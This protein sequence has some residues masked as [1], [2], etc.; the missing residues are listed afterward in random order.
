MKDRELRN[1]LIFLAIYL[2]CYCGILILVTQRYRA[3]QMAMTVQK[4]LL[5]KPSLSGAQ[6][7]AVREFRDQVSRWEHE[8]M[9][10]RDQ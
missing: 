9:G 4:K 3:K 8:Q 10:T 1:S 6:E 2:V 7:I 5:S